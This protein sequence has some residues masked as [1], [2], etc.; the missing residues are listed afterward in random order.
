MRVGLVV[1]GGIDPSG[2]TRVIPALL[3]LIEALAERHEV[4]VH[5]LFHSSSPKTYEIAGARVFDLGLLRRR[6]FVGLGFLDAVRALKRSVAENGPPHVLHA[7]W[8]G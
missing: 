3:W 4:D 8:A 5:V 7:F 2:R 6:L 1:P